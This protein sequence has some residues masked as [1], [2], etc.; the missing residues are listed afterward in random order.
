MNNRTQTGK[1]SPSCF[2]G[3]VKFR[4]LNVNK[5]IWIIKYKQTNA[6]IQVQIALQE[7]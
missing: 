7:K 2:V 3:E 1:S 5:Q 4:L 6:D